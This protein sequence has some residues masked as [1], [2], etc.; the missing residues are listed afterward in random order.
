[1]EKVLNKNVRSVKL[2]EKVS[3]KTGRNYTVIEIEFS[4]GYKYTGFLNIDQTYILGT[5]GE[6]VK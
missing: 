3:A 6:E 5:F 4:S 2:I 1:M